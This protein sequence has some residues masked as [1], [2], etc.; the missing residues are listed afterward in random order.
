MS[1]FSTEGTVV[2]QKDFKIL[3]VV[4]NEFF[5]AVGKKVLGSV[6]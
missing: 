6:I 4:Y 5:K 1:N 3:G 2:H